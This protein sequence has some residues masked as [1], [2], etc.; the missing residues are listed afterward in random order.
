MLASPDSPIDRTMNA[1]NRVTGPDNASRVY[2]ID[3]SVYV[4]RA[5]FS[6]PET[7]VNA[8]GQPINAIQ[9]FGGFLADLKSRVGKDKVIAVAF[10][11]S[12]T[13]SFRNQ[14]YPEYKANRPPAPESLK[15]QFAWCRDLCA[16]LRLP[17]HSDE[18]Y[19]A[20]DIIG[21]W[22]NEARARGD[23]VTVVTRDKDLTQLVE[24]GDTWW[25]FAADTHLAPAGV[26]EKMGV[27]PAQVADW[28]ALTGDA[29]DNIPG[30]KGVGPKA[31]T[32]LLE[33]FGSLEAVYQNLDAVPAL[34]IRGAKS[35]AAKLAD[36]EELARMSHRLTLIPESCPRVPRLI[37][38]PANADAD[39]LSSVF[40]DV[41]LGSGLRRRL[42]VYG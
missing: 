13:T 33:H 6:L 29:V 26:K 19:E 34:P 30:V 21:H 14:I 1:S 7:M 36:N 42:Q 37:S 23:R 5:F 28:L 18:E 17:V 4:F 35:L 2:L 40:H 16:A 27:Y 20:D 10:D 38:A 15:Q 8:A 22:A 25:D 32:A 12:L 24:D 31:A 3:A 39:A 9:G 41:G 11:A